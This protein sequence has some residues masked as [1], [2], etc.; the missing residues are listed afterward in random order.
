MEK[1]AEKI[2][3]LPN[4]L[5]LLRMALIPV[6]IAVYENGRYVEALAVFLVAGLTDLLDGRIARRYHLV[7][8]FGKIMDPLA[9]KLMC[10]TV[11][12]SLNFSGTIHWAFVILVA[13]KELLMLLGGAYLLGKGIVIQ[14]RKV[15]KIAQGLFIV[16]LS[17]SFFHDFFA[18][19]MLQLD[20][21]VL[22][23]AVIMTLL[24]SIFYAVSALKAARELAWKERNTMQI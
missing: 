15:G 3:N 7:T 19:W 2:W 9:D 6:Y 14:S 21:I 8:N 16:A 4:T 1:K 17:L 18:G 12:F 13:A 20:V 22:W 11:L 23:A 10:L 5:T 24:A